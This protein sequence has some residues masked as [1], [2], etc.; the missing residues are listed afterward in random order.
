MTT[1]IIIPEPLKAKA[2]E[3][4]M[5]DSMTSDLLTALAEC[6]VSGGLRG[7]VVDWDAA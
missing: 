1:E 5:P 4:A 3:L 6:I 7:V 2:R